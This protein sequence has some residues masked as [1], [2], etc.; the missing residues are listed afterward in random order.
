MKT[1]IV[2]D[3]D[4]IRQRLVD[5]LSDFPEVEIIGQEGEA[6]Q[7]IVSIRLEKPDLVILDIGLIGGNGIDV[8]H[9]IKRDNPD[10]KVIM[11]TSYPVPQHQRRCME[12]GADAFLDKSNGFKHI[13]PIVESFAVEAAARMKPSP[14]DKH[15]NPSS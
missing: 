8:L 1:I 5:I 14:T 12:E 11:L 6:H 2:D 3:S 13:K 7:A 10:I 15:L 4:L 9:E